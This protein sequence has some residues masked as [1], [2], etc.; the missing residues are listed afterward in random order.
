MVVT[1]SATTVLFTTS[2]TLQAD[3]PLNKLK[4][5]TNKTFFIKTSPELKT[6]NIIINSII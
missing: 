3:N 4:P 1:E 5:K 2:V 6:N